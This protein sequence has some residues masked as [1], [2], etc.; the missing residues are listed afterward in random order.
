MGLSVVM[1]VQ[2]LHRLGWALDDGLRLGELDRQR[3]DDL[4]LGDGQAVQ[5]ARQLVERLGAGLHADALAALA[6]VVELERVVLGRQLLE[7]GRRR[8]DR[9]RVSGPL[10]L[11]KSRGTMPPGSSRVVGSYRRLA[12]YQRTGDGRRGT[13]GQPGARP[14]AGQPAIA[15]SRAASVAA[16]SA[17]SAR[18]EG[19]R[20]STTAA[21]ARVV[22]AASAEAG[23]GRRQLPLGIGELPLE[24]GSLALDGRPS[25]ATAAPHRP[26]R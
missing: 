6:V 5:H 14:R 10:R 16:C 4:D 13:D 23:L 8:G 25:R 24:A 1:R 26:P 9:L 7:D 2:P 17:S 12:S 20:P 15:A 11:R 3:L 21:G 22:K 19:G 18:V